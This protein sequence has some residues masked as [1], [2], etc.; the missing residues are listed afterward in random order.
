[1]AG[2]YSSQTGGEVHISSV[3]D[4]CN[5][6]ATC[7]LSNDVSMDDKG[8]CQNIFC[9]SDKISFHRPPFDWSDMSNRDAL[10]TI[11]NCINERIEYYPGGLAQRFV[12]MLGISY[13]KQHVNPGNGSRRFRV[14]ALWQRTLFDVSHFLVS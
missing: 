14:F 7:L 6:D 9:L 12:E 11:L 2:I 3:L 13:P 4:I 8:R 5:I 1:M 10:K